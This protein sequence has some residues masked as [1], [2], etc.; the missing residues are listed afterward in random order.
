MWAL[1]SREHL[2]WLRPWKERPWNKPGACE[3]A[4]RFCR[5][6]WL[7][8][9]ADL[10]L[11]SAPALLGAIWMRDPRL[12]AVAAMVGWYGVPWLGQQIRS[13]LL[14][15]VMLRVIAAPLWWLMLPVDLYVFW[16]VWWRSQ[17][18]DPTHVNVSTALGM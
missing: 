4:D 9:V 13:C 1:L 6:G 10:A 3:Y 8:L 11:V 7:R 18:Y 2:R 16:R 12:L 17:T 14:A 15:D 5:G